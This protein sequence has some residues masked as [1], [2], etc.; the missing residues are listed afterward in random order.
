MAD[1]KRTARLQGA[2]QQGSNEK[3]I[4]VQHTKCQSYWLE[5]A[6]HRMDYAGRD[7]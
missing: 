4:N 1:G 3:R 7:I 5:D 6:N 2:G